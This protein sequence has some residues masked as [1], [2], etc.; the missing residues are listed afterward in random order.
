MFDETSP[1][2]F[3][4]KTLEKNLRFEWPEYHINFI[5]DVFMQICVGF[6]RKNCW[7]IQVEL[8]NQSIWLEYSE[9]Q[10]ILQSFDLRD[11]FEYR[12]KMIE[13][14]KNQLAQF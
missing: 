9:A 14:W 8:L 3:C 5:D 2:G 7:C 12:E 6:E 10:T 4:L 11:G 13:N 1:V